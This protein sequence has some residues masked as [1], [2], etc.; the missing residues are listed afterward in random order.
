VNTLNWEF[1]PTNGGD[2]TGSNDP[3]TSVFKGGGD[4]FYHLARESIQNVID[5]RDP[6]TSKPAIAKISLSDLQPSDFPSSDQL[7]HVLSLCR[8]ECKT[9]KDD[10][11]FYTRAIDNLARNLFIPV[12]KISDYNTTGLVGKDNDKDGGYFSLMKAVGSSSK[13]GPAGGSY[14]LGK[15]AYFRASSFRTIFVSSKIGSNDFVFQGKA[16]LSSFKENEKWMQG[17]GCCGLEEQKP[18]RDVS[19]IPPFFRRDEIGTD[20]Y[21]L[22]YE[23]D[24]NWK[25]AMVKSILNNFWYAIS[26]GILEIDIEGTEINADSLENLLE[27]NFDKNSPDKKGDEN[28]WPYYLSYRDGKLI[29]KKLPT[30]GDVEFYLM[31]GDN[32]P[33]KIV[34]LRKI[35]M[36]IQKKGGIAAPT[37]Y[38]GVFVCKN[39]RGNKIL[40]KMENP[41]HDEWALENARDSEFASDAENAEKEM[42]T[43]IKESVNTTFSNK[44]A[45]SLNVG[46]LEEFLWLEGDLGVGGVFGQ[47]LDE[48]ATQTETGTEMGK[49][50][51]KDKN[52][53]ITRK[54]EVLKEIRKGKPG[55]TDHGLGGTTG[56]GEGTWHEDEGGVENI[57]VL[58]NLKFRSFAS[59]RSDGVIEHAVIIKGPPDTDCFIE[60]MAG[61]DDSFDEVPV[62][63]AF[64]SNNNYSISGNR[65]NGLKLDSSGNLKIKIIFKDKER[66]SLNITAYANK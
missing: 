64:D 45:Q 17:N 46:G 39:D 43:F 49:E 26:E 2:W 66:Y 18:V 38:A 63:K 9:N 13:S 23:G 29:Q 33:N 59:K 44:N 48:T 36:I 11:G 47:Q 37:T 61:T 40:K 60:V 65:I 21:I 57:L 3:V 62:E 14:G 55:G 10:Y 56:S 50:F 6:E 20:I 8:E 32:F 1:A 30:L 52:N 7:L 58:K 54:L 4:F 27:K 53:I 51:K 41:S 5:A 35:G 15:G 12:L 16:R 19:L 25:S 31:E 34:Y 22:G 42:K 24:E 28:P